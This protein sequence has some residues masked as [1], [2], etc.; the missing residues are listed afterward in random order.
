VSRNF[1]RST[2][3]LKVCPSCGKKAGELKETELPARFPYRVV[4]NAC[5]FTTDFVKLPG[6][7]MKLWNEA[8]SKSKAKRER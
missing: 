7:A 1:C 6:V 2:V 8:R 5:G 4:C 3:D